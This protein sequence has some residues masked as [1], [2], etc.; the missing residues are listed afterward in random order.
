M[1]G[2]RYDST[3]NRRGAAWQSGTFGL[4]EEAPAQTE[5]DPGTG[6]GLKI[7]RVPGPPEAEQAQLEPVTGVGISRTTDTGVGEV[8][9]S[10]S[11][12]DRRPIRGQINTEDQR[13]ERAEAQPLE[14]HTL[15]WGVA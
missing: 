7:R 5:P 3:T 1:Q 8:T 15:F 6:K 2:S 12:Q 4:P 9:D 11:A 10:C 14:G 13:R